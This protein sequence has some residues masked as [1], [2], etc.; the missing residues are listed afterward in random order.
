MITAMRQLHKLGFKK[1]GLALHNGINQESEYRFLGGYLAGSHCCCP[2][3]TSIPIF[4]VEEGNTSK[5]PFLSWFKENRPQVIICIQKE[6][7][8]WLKEAGYQV[9]QDVSLV[10]LALDSVGKGWAGMR[11]DR[12]KR[13][14]MAIEDIV[15]Q[16]NYNHTGA[17][18]Y[19]KATLNESSWELGDTLQ[20]PA[21]TL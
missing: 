10:S 3:L 9:P 1:I 2:G 5:T 18:S 4:L 16:I 21:Q 20:I 13:G 11:Q 6:P 7:L 17:T 15:A 12:H 8:E 14:E 19:Q